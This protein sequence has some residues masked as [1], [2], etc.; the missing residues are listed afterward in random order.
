MSIVHKLEF[1]LNLVWMLLCIGALS[2]QMWRDGL[3]SGA[4]NRR[5]RLR[6]SLS[7]LITALALFPVISASDDRIRLADL[8]AVPVQQ[9]A[10]DRGQTHGPL[11]SASIEDPEHGQTVD[12]F[13][14]ITIVCFFLIVQ[15]SASVRSRWSSI[16]TFGRA[17][18]QF[19]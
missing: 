16:T 7:V 19:A 9:S 5:I 2:A 14:L 1:T 11:S 18:P 15:M 10:F 4:R 17:P 3:G 13:F 12:P 8:Q 6:H